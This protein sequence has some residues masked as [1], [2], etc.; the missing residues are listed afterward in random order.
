MR[1]QPKAFYREGLSDQHRLP[2]WLGD[3]ESVGQ[4]RRHGFSSQVWKTPWRRKWQP[5]PVLLP[6]QSHGQRSLAGYV[7]G[8]VVKNQ[9]RLN[10]SLT[11]T[12]DQCITSTWKWRDIVNRNDRAF[13]PPPSHLVPLLRSRAGHGKPRPSSPPSRQFTLQPVSYR[14]RHHQPGRGWWM[15]LSPSPL[16][17]QPGIFVVTITC[18]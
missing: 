14:L 1:D 7:H 12:S 10:D 17:F 15:Q 11:T 8:V 13:L 3:K 9:T 18:D 16:K 2:W 4:C 6:R 5:T